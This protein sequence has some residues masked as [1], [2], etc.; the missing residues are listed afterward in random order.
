MQ[1]DLD[2]SIS[3][4]IKHKSTTILWETPILNDLPATY[5]VL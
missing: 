4:S 2:K 3:T 5:Y 1:Q